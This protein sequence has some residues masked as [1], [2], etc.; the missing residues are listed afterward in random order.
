MQPQGLIF[1]GQRFGPVCQKQLNE[2]K[3]SQWPIE[4]P[5]LDDAPKLRG[6]YFIDPADAEFKE[7]LKTR[8]EKVGTSDGSCYAL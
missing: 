6:I 4:K 3:S 1:C 5:I 7:T 8:K 2:R